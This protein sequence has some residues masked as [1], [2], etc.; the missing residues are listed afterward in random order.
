[1]QTRRADSQTNTQ[2]VHI[3][4]EQAEKLVIQSVGWNPGKIKACEEAS[5]RASTYD[6]TKRHRRV[7]NRAVKC[8]RETGRLI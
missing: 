2:L 7:Q 4:G 3:R 8:Q 6:Y 1:M 5:S